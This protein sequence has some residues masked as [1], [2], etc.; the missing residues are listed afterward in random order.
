MRLWDVM[1]QKHPLPLGVGVI[2]EDQLLLPKYFL[3]L[4][5]E[6]G[7]F[8]GDVMADLHVPRPGSVIGTITQNQRVT[9]DA[10]WQDVRHMT[11]AL[12]EPVLYVPGDTVSL[13]PKNFPEDVDHFLSLQSW[14][15]IADTPLRLRPSAGVFT[16]PPILHPISPL[17]LRTL[18]THH[19]DITSIP[20]RSFFAIIANLTTDQTHKERLQELTN[21]A[22]LDDL[23]DYTTRP[24]RSILEVLQ[25]FSS[26]R[27]PL[28]MLLE[29]IPRMRERLFSIA[30]SARVGGPTPAA[31]STNLSLLVAIVKYK[32]I[33]R[34]IRQGVCTRWLSSLSPG[35]PISI[36]I[37]RG[38]LLPPVTS[39]L[40]SKPAL[41]IAPGTGVAPM[42]ALIWE[43]VLAPSPLF[44]NTLV[45]GSRNRAAD[46]FFESEW[47]EFARHGALRLFTA[48]S[49]DQV[50]KRYV[51]TAIREQAKLVWDKVVVNG[52]VVYVCGSSG[53][54]PTAVREALIE[55]FEKVGSM[56][57]QESEAYLLEMQ[58][59]GRFRQETW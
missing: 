20:R 42:R 26:V 30:S 50:A 51:Q 4:G 33:I 53:R 11:I 1:L 48:F 10:H 27:I 54:M 28:P 2:P 22:F 3:E 7:G 21:P 49:R 38:S 13:L 8:V 32:T 15:T 55:V 40:Y 47:E 24:R 59:E 19:L 57:R 41:M 14:T 9:P 46:F 5:N 29:V 35:A 31:G 23:Y 56:S 45:F 43:R 39:P 58:R 25:E 44:D 52:G 12:L 17:T 37:T 34:R 16:P 18:L 6:A 36:I